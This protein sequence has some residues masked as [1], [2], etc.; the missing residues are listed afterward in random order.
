MA[1]DFFFQIHYCNGQKLKGPGKI[2]HGVTRTLQHHVLIL[3]VEADG[4]TT[5]GGTRYPIQ[6]GMLFYIPPGVEQ[7][8]ER[9]FPVLSCN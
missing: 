9:P 1:V 4:H 6:S 7:T 8:M 5:I 2:T 3:A